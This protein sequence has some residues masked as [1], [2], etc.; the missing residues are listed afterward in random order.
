MTAPTAKVRE[1][2]YR[3]DGHQCISCGNRGMLEWNHRQSSGMGG[4]KYK[5][6]PADGVTSCRI[7]NQAYE[8]ELQERALLNGWKVRRFCP[9][10]VALVPVYYPFEHQW[11][12]LNTDGSRDP[13]TET[14]AAEYRGMAGLLPIEQEVT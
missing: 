8:A 3:R 5:P 14:E 1:E 9:V 2:T 7:C 4:S 13:L 6:N 11:Y 12:L 10:V